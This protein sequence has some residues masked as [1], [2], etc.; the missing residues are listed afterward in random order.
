M[1]YYNA[2]KCFKESHDSV[3]LD[4]NPVMHNLYT[5]LY[6]LSEAIEADMTKIQQFLSQI[7]T[8]LQRL[9]QK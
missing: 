3:D 1:S 9:E 5:G 2:K 6:Q 7:A 8:R 4:S